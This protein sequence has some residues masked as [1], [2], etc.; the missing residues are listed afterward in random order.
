M[1]LRKLLRDKKG[2]DMNEIIRIL[3]WILFFAIAGGI[4]FLFLRK[5]GVI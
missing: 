4:L 1:N 5:M 2:A 3:M